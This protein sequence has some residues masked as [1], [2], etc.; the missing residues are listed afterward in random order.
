MSGRPLHANTG[1]A[2]ARATPPTKSRSMSSPNSHSPA[3]RAGHSHGDN[4]VDML[5]NGT[6]LIHIKDVPG[7]VFDGDRWQPE[8][9]YL[10][11][12]DDGDRR[13]PRFHRHKGRSQGLQVPQI[14]L[15]LQRQLGELQHHVQSDGIGWRRSA[16]QDVSQ[17]AIVRTGLLGADARQQL[18]LPPRHQ[19]QCHKHAL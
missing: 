14:Y 7:R 15:Q 16:G 18:H 6:A 11:F 4:D 9:R 5:D 2:A 10:R 3:G 8:P 12:V 19:L 13:G 1:W 17:V